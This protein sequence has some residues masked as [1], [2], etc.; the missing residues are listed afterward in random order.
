MKSIISVRAC[1]FIKMAL[2]QVLQPK[3]SRM[4]AAPAGRSANARAS[5]LKAMINVG[6]VS[7]VEMIFGV[8]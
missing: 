5:H 6:S 7:R 2:M 4:T 3:Q 1:A 8:K